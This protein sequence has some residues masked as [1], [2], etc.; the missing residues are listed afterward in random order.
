MS[1]CDNSHV[2]FNLGLVKNQWYGRWIQNKTLRPDTER[3]TKRELSSI[4]D[5]LDSVSIS[6]IMDFPSLMHT[7]SSMNHLAG[8]VG[9]QI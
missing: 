1:I 8:L 6:L 3:G 2:I 7:N 9:Y 5:F 4:H